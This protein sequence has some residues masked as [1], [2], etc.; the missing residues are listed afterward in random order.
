MRDVTVAPLCAHMY[1]FALSRCVRAAPK[2]CIC[3]CQ[4]LS[5]FTKLPVEISIDRSNR[6]ICLSFASDRQVTYQETPMINVL[7]SN[8]VS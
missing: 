6:L 4:E 5:S 8:P 2:D 3:T 1:H 7:T